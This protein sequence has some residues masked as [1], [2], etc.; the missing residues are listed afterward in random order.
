M[1]FDLTTIDNALILHGPG[2]TIMTYLHEANGLFCTCLCVG[3][4]T[5]AGLLVKSIASSAASF[6]LL[7]MQFLHSKV[8]EKVGREVHTRSIVFTD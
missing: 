6:R 7:A 8:Q 1:G 2:C 3:V 5:G 4:D